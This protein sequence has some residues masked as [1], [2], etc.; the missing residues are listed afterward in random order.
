MKNNRSSVL[1]DMLVH[2]CNKKNPRRMNQENGLEFE[3]GPWVVGA[4]MVM[5]LIQRSQAIQHGSILSS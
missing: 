1:L 3:D 4:G 2:L 5:E